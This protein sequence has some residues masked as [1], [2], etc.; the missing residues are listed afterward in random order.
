MPNC[1]IAQSGGPTAVINSS[2]VGLLKENQKSNKF[3]KVYGGLNGI[4]GILNENII[5]LTAISMEDIARFQY[6]PSSGLGSCRYK[7]KDISTSTEEYD[8][9]LDILKKLDITTFFYIGGNDSMDTTAKLGKYAKENSLDITFIG[10]PKTIDNDL[11]HTDHTPGFGSAAKFIATTTLEAYFDSSVYINNGIFILE[12]MGRDAGWLAA[13]ACMAQYNGKP[14]AD[15]IYLPEK[16]FDIIE[17]IEDVRAKFQE[18][19]QV[20]IVVSE[21]LRNSVGRFVTEF[22]CVSQDTFGHAQLGGVSNFLRQTILDAGISTRV[23]ALELGILQRCAMHSA[24]QTDIDEAFNAGAEALRSSEPENNGCMV[25][26]KRES[27]DSYKVSYELVPADTVANNVKYFPVD[28]INEKGNHI[29]EEAYEYFKPLLEGVPT[30][31]T[32]NNV[33][34]YKVF[35]K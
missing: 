4:E 1:I 6:T 7:M 35:T 29:N 18:Q 30:L 32:F 28:W 27:N 12:T 10:I 23:K 22:D 2:V 31:Y 25:S 24:S 26:I 21:G 5:D 8:K 15:F 16:P 20:F 34:Q 19:N 17:F 3:E 9:L 33:P 13:S 11:M 14:V